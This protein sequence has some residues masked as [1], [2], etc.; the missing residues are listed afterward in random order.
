[1]PRVVERLFRPLPDRW[2]HSVGR[3]IILVVVPVLLIGEGPETRGSFSA[4]V[5]LNN[6]WELRAFGVTHQASPP[7]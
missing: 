3:W 7:T 6:P 5:P 1:M 4:I 2:L